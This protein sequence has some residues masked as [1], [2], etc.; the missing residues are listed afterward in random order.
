MSVSGVVPVKRVVPM[1]LAS[2]HMRVV[3][4]QVVTVLHPDPQEWRH[5]G[6]AGT[7]VDRGSPACTIAR[8]RV[9]QYIERL[10]EMLTGMLW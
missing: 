7:T 3:D 5:G 4:D 2:E 8:A 10:V 9:I 6:S 1:P